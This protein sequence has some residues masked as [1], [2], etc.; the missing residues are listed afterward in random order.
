MNI[1]ISILK[2]PPDFTGAGLRTQQMYHNLQDRGVVDQVYVIT[3]REHLTTKHRTDSD[4]QKI[5]YVGFNPYVE[6]Q[7]TYILRLKKTCFVFQA[8]I[9][10]IIQ[11]FKTFRNIDIVHTI[12]ASWLSTIVGWC[13]FLTDKPFV[14]EVVSRGADDP[15][16]IIRHKSGLR[17]RFFLF[18]FK[19]AKMVIVLSQ[20]L[21]KD[22]LRY[23]IPSQKIWHRY[24]PIYLETNAAR[25]MDQE[26]IKGIDDTKPWILNVGRIIRR[27]NTHFLLKSAFHLNGEVQLLF[28]G[29]CDDLD[30]ET[31]VHELATKLTRATNGRVKT[32][33]LDR[34]TD[35]KKLSYLYR[36]SKLFWFASIH[37]GLPNAVLE[38]L[39]SGTPVLT[40]AV[41]GLMKEIIKDDQDG[42]VIEAE[43]P[44]QFA[45]AANKWL[46]KTDIDRFGIAE[47]ARRRFDPRI[48]E[49]EYVMKFKQIIA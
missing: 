26:L 38:S 35:R 34:V 1:L 41:G 37:E 8:G 14:K 11:Y 7:T 23:G 25:G 31:E 10:A 48:V 21:K 12:D 22:C 32:A 29:P 6:K 45:D 4:R 43:N 20:K 2:Y 27:K 42:E 5:A 17:R 16:S 15:L 3:T 44:V 33:F 49:D 39:L 24:N 9:R 40:L 19:Q 36:K 47:R 46:R 28:V 13:A 18:P 30:Y